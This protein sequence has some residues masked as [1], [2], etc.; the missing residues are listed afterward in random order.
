MEPKMRV[1][2]I[3]DERYIRDLC[4]DF[5]S[6]RGFEVHTLDRGDTALSFIE[7]TP[8]DIILLDIK[9][10]GISGLELLS[11]IRIAYPDIE[12]VM[13]TGYSSIESAVQMIKLGAYDYLPKPL[14]LVKLG[15]ILDHIRDK[16]I[17]E[18]KAQRLEWQSEGGQFH[19]IVGKSRPML[20]VFSII[21]SLARYSINV[22]IIGE[23]GTGKELVA[24]VIHELS[25]RSD[26]PFVPCNCSALVDTLLE[27]ELFGHV[28]GAF[29]GAVRTKRGLF[30]IADGGT[31]FLDEVGEL[32]IA[33]QVKLLRA[34]EG[35]EIQPIGSEEILKVDVRV[36]A[37]TNRN[38]H[39]AVEEGKFR[40]DL[41]HRLNVA[42]IYLPPL[43]ERK[44]DIPLLCEHFLK[45]FSQ[46][47][48]KDIRG[49]SP[50]AMSVIESYPWYGNVRELKNALERATAVA[51]GRYIELEDLPPSIREN[52]ET[53]TTAQ[54]SEDDM[55]LERMEMEHI[56][57]V[58]LKTSGNKVRAAQILGISRR[59]LYRKIK[60]YGIDL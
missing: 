28:K 8:V 7:R 55:S 24:R 35:G 22:L 12:V 32:P 26:K 59:S 53:I 11:K 31:I 36:L 42:S 34:I 18:E 43:R 16:K 6:N 13:I 2:I 21:K 27:S 5:L 50:Q 4:S 60:K 52:N 9:L 38:L 15:N 49:V 19:G 39:A 29:T 17:L 3:D 58:L 54:A 30:S 40:R 33:T 20:E 41:Y 46:Q 14:D 23:T 1:L 45:S 57:S 51:K 48:G 56:R 10:P 25:P 47:L 37:A 44:E